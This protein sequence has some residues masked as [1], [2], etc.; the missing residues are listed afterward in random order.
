MTRSRT[1]VSLLASL[2]LDTLM[3]GPAL[4]ALSASPNPSTTGS[5][6]VSGS[7]TTT[8]TYEWMSLIETAPGGATAYYGVSDPG[9]ISESFSSKSVGTYSYQVEGC[10]FDYDPEFRSRSKSARTW[11]PRFRSASSSRRRST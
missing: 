11:A 1:I 9:S 6:T 2:V 10:Y 3:A 5:Y 7:V 8:R 4:G